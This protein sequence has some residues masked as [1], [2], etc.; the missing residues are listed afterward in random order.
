MAFFPFV[1]HPRNHSAALIAVRPSFSTIR[2]KALNI[3]VKV[4]YSL[5]VV[6]A[7]LE[8][9]DPV[10]T[11]RR[12]PDPFASPRPRPTWSYHHTGT[13]NRLI[14][15]V[16]H[17]CENT[18]GVWVFFPFWNSTASPAPAW[19]N[20]AASPFV[21]FLFTVRCRL[22]TV[23]YSVLLFSKLKAPINHAEST[24]LEVFF[25]KQLKVPLKSTLFTKQGGG[26]PL[27][28]TNCSTKVYFV[29]RALFSTTYGNPIFQLLSFQ[30]H[31]GMGGV[32]PR[33]NLLLSLP[34]SRRFGRSDLQTF[35]CVLCIP[36]GV[37]GRLYLPLVVK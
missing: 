1:S 17:S 26:S 28:L 30:F 16:S 4:C 10:G 2:C 36:N 31:A 3:F 29:P 34:L 24:V 27:W 18:G 21:G 22:T 20:K 6:T 13:L 32:P 12:P 15:F 23:S 25:L 37:T 8:D 9:S 35:R 11:P 5:P 7:M 14:S 19:S 33:A